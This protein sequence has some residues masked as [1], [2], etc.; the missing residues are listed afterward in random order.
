ML[1][2]FPF[3]FASCF[4]HVVLLFLTTKIETLV[5]TASGLPD[6]CYFPNCL[7]TLFSGVCTQEVLCIYNLTLQR[8]ARVNDMTHRDTLHKILNPIILFLYSMKNSD[9]DTAI[10]SIHISCLI[11]CVTPKRSFGSGQS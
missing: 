2:T 7:T 6:R 3:A 1:Q 5:L 10:N 8:H 9:L 4:Q 11:F